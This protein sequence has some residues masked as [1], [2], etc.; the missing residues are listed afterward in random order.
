M[1]W[2]A[3]SRYCSGFSDSSLW[4]RIDPSGALPT[5]SVNVPPR[6]IQN[7]QPECITRHV[8]PRRAKGLYSQAA[9]PG[10]TAAQ[11]RARSRMPVGCPPMSAPVSS[12]GVFEPTGGTAQRGDHA[13]AD[14]SASSGCCCSS[15]SRSRLCLL[16][17]SP[18]QKW[19]VERGAS[20]AIGRQVT[21]GDPFRLRAWPPI[22]ITAADIRS[23][24]PIGARRRSSRGWIASTPARSPRVLA[25][26]PGRGRPADRDQAAAQSRDRRGRAQELGFR[27]GDQAAGARASRRAKPIPG[28]VL[29]DV[30]IEGGVV[31]FDDR[32][33]KQ[34][35]APRRSTSRSI[36]AAPTSR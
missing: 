16:V 27:G 36:R 35:G 4:M 23:P 6:S 21:F 15:S 17:P 14:Q 9:A 32:A 22:A 33:G 5:T 25:R 19:A 30:R 20:M 24:M 10:P 13:Q 18:L 31:S 34:A 12:T 2:I 8:R 29:G 26:E 3:A 7:C 28:F 1:P 11:R